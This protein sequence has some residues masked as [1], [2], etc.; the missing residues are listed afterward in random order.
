[1]TDPSTRQ[2][3]FSLVMITTLFFMWGFVHNLDPIL[4]PH[5][6]RSFSLTVLES[7][8]VDS[9]VFIAYFVMA[10]PAGLLI[11]RAGYKAAII[12]GL[13]LFATGSLM[14][15]PAAN[16]QQYIV[17]LAALFTIACGLTI[18][19]TAANPYVTLLG[20]PE[21]AAQRINLAQSFNGL[22]ATLAPIIG[23]R[24]ILVHGA[25]DA[26]LAAMPAAA[27]QAALA[28]EAASVKGP[29]MVL[30][31]VILVI[32]IV[33][34]FLK[35]PEVAAGAHAGNREAKSTVGAALRVPSIRRG[36]VAQFFY[37]GA[38][39]CV[40]SFFILYA[41]KSAGVSPVTA[42]DYLGW[43]CGMAFMVGRFVGTALMRVVAP[44]RLLWMYA[45][46]CIAL[47][48]VAM[49]AQGLVSIA[50]VI[51]IAF[52]MSIMFPT[53]FSLGLNGAGHH[54]DMGS[55]LIIMSIVGGALLP[56]LFGFVSDVT[57]NVQFGYAV[58]LVCFVVIAWFARAA[59]AQDSRDA[60]A[61]APSSIGVTKRV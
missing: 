28:A 48:A 12:C 14:F 24:L 51:G 1:M 3:R 9:A 13:L 6:R 7:A 40:F 56:L 27:R 31:L 34:Y 29:Y 59:L 46:A 44:A 33:F 58:P 18:L 2:Y 60:R 45:L 26:Q 32:A 17:F 19:E 25:N 52:F 38:Q 43:G 11:R 42:A 22:A 4:I 39:V 35:L 15:I 16:T 30:G 8:L 61:A 50:A 5:L 20:R 21:K 23:A 54:A 10:L 41:T 47:A 53:I 57:H 36:A 37:V 49:V 55:G